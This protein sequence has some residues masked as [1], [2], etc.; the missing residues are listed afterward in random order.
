[1]ANSVR[2]AATTRPT[3]AAAAATA[4][5]G[6]GV[7]RAA[8]SFAMGGKERDSPRCLH[9]LAILALDERVGLTHRSQSIEFRFAILTIILV[10]R[11][12]YHQ[13]FRVLHQIADIFYSG[14]PNPSRKAFT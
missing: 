10:Y 11:H 14:L 13:P 7:R 9:A 3:G 12:S 6:H 4:A 8:V 2:A 1:M 5:T